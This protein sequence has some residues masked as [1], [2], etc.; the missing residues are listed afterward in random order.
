MGW[1]CAF[2]SIFRWI[3][4]DWITKRWDQR[5]HE[6]KIGRNCS[7][8]MQSVWCI[9]TNTERWSSSWAMQITNLPWR[10]W[11]NLEKALIVSSSALQSKSLFFKSFLTPVIKTYDWWTTT[12]STC[13][14]RN[15]W[16]CHL[17]MET[18]RSRQRKSI[19]R[20]ARNPHWNKK[21][22]RWEN[23]RALKEGAKISITWFRLET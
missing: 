1:V 17:R 5:N 9:C 8:Y 21:K 2:R 23:N 18:K 15:D 3:N 11:L 14:N 6:W 20:I 4:N 13:R 10:L 22:I 16:N 7:I 19:L 12:K